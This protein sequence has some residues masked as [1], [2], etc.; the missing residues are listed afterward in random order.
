M[1]Q[2]DLISS[3]WLDLVFDGRNTEYGAYVLRQQTGRRNM[4]AIASV[5]LMVAVISAV[6]YG[7]RATDKYMSGAKYDEVITLVN[8]PEKEQTKVERVEQPKQPERIIENLRNSIK[9]V[10]PKIMEDDKVNPEEM[11]RSQDE[12]N[13]SNT[14]IAAVNVTNGSD[15]GEIIHLNEAIAQIEPKHEEVDDTPL[16][17]VEQMPMFPGGDAEMM[18]FLG[19][20]IKYPVICQETGIQGRVV[21]GFVVEKDGSITDVQVIRSVDPNL[22]KEAVRV[23]KTMPKWIPGRQNGRPVRVKYIVPVAFRLQ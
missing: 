21:C 23:I 7:L 6:F 20:N 2:I 22:D 13:Q 8:L 15:H 3:E 19:K 18:R 11:M 17:V 14:A 4:W 10:A 9:F 12:L 16:Q 5:A 1:K